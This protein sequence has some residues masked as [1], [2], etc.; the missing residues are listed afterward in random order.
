VALDPEP[1]IEEASV[2]VVAADQ[3]DAD[4]QPVGSRAGR[5]CEARHV[6]HSP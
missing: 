1:D 6:K 5:Q 3:L 2:V 4:R